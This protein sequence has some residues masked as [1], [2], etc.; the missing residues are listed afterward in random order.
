MVCFVFEAYIALKSFEAAAAGGGGGGMLHELGRQ[1]LSF[2]SL[3]LFLF[4]APLWPLFLAFILNLSF[5]SH[6]SQPTSGQLCYYIFQ[7]ILSAA[8]APLQP[9]IKQRGLRSLQQCAFRLRAEQI[10]SNQAAA[11]TTV[12]AAAILKQLR[13]S[14]IPLVYAHTLGHGL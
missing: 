14:R 5:H 10:V 8:S 3:L 4:L 1:L 12:S 7:I 11:S 9:S 13:I 2:N 6:I